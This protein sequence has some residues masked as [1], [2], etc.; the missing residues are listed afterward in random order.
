MLLLRSSLNV[1]I[2]RTGLPVPYL[3][4]LWAAAIAG[5]AVSWAVKLTLLPPGPILAAV[6]ILGPYGLAFFAMTAALRVP[7]ASS[8]LSTLAGYLR[9]PRARD[10]P[11]GRS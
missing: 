3:A 5:A 2:G 4:S 9:G 10:V 1:R 8:A 6:F 11:P 7:E